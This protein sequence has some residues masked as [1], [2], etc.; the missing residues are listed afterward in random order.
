M[1]K[2]VRLKGTVCFSVCNGSFLLKERPIGFKGKTHHLLC[3][4]NQFLTSSKNSKTDQLP[5]TTFYLINPYNP[6]SLFLKIL[7]LVN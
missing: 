3:I 4:S 1:K 6:A 2:H 5:Q 7:L